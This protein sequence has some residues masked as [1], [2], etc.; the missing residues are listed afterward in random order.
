MNI[1]DAVLILII[2]LCGLSGFKKGFTK[3]VVSFIGFFAIIILAFL[4][5]NKISVLLYTNLSFFNFGLFKQLAVYNILLYEV[6]AFFLLAGILLIIFRVLMMISG[7]FEKL[8][9]ITV[10]LG[11]PSKILGFIV[12]LIEGYVW[13]FII[14]FVLSLT[15]FNSTE[16]SKSKFKDPILEK[17]PILSSFTSDIN[18]AVIEITDFEKKNADKLE[19]N[20]F[21][22]KAL[23]IMLKYKIIS[24]DSIK[25][26][27]EKGKLKIKN[28]D[29]LLA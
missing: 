21:N 7:I 28:I 14:S 6:I 12:G 10:V 16:L 4:F 3:E 8:L 5:K 2:L 24:K 15:L 25:K 26:L 9:S 20:E 29:K 27:D 19:P 11:I 1:V 17:T 22:Y 13:V 18:G 23:Q